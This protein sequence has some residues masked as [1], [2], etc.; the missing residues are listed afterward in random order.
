MQVV[1][2]REQEEDREKT[3]GA[4]LGRNAIIV[5]EYTLSNNQLFWD[6]RKS[7]KNQEFWHFVGTIFKT[8]PHKNGVFQHSPLRP[9]LSC[10][11]LVTPLERDND[12]LLEDVF[13]ICSAEEKTASPPLDYLY[14][15]TRVRTTQSYTDHATL[16]I[17]AN[18][19]ISSKLCVRL[20][21][22]SNTQQGRARV[23]SWSI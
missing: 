17:M 23:M 11:C 14:S 1:E 2:W 15:T 21:L 5:T 4:H 7:L 12:S 19:A 16:M 10:T 9:L 20:F 18:R 6:C 8:K 13:G 22:M 3:W